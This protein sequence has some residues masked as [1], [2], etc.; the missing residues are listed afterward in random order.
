MDAWPGIIEAYRDLLPVIAT[1]S[2]DVPVGTVDDWKWRGPT[3]AL[4]TVAARLGA[5]D[6]ADRAARVWERASSR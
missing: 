4:A 1:T 3:P 5:P 6:L 2:L